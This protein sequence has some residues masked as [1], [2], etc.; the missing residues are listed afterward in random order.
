MS[1]IDL[2]NPQ[3]HTPVCARVVAWDDHG[4]VKTPRHAAEEQQSIES[5]PATPEG[6]SRIES[7]IRIAQAEL[8]RS[9]DDADK[10]REKIRIY[11]HQLS[12]VRL[13]TK[14]AQ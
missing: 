5:V 14:G 3:I 6:I 12:L 1:L 2:I 13:K 10:A 8:A 9:L 4:K 7:R 11:S